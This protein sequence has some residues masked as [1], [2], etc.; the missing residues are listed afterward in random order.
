MRVV[1]PDQALDSIRQA[2]DRDPR[3]RVLGVAGP[4][5]ALANDATLATFNL[6]RTS[7]PSLPAASRPTAYCCPTVLMRLIVPVSLR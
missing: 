7:F 5:D 1:S 2:V 6:V 4:G 3:L